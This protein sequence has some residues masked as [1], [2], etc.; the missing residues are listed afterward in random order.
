MLPIISATATDSAGL[1]LHRLCPRC[2]RG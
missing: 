2:Q 1:T